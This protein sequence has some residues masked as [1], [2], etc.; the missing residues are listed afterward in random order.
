MR[1]VLF[2]LLTLVAVALPLAAQAPQSVG[3]V[4]R[5]IPAG[6][7]NRG[8]STNE[9]KK[10]DPVEW[11]D[12]L[13]TNDAGRMRVAMDDGSLL[14]IGAHSELRVIK[15]DPQSN[16]TVIEML[17]GKARANVV[18]IKKQ[19]GSFQVRTPTA[20]IG[21]LGTT[22]DV[23]TVQLVGTVTEKD[24]EELP[25]SRRSVADLIQL[26]P[27]A[28]P[29]KSRPDQPTIADYL[30][31][32]TRVTARD[33]AVAVRSIDPEILKT[34]VVLPGYTT[35]VPRGGPPSDP[36]PE[37]GQ[38]QD[39]RGQPVRN[40]EES[41]KRPLLGSCPQGAVTFDSL[42]D[43]LEYEIVGRGT[44]TGSVF[45]VRVKNL[46]DCPLN[47]QIPAGAVLEPKGYVGRVL[48]GIL[49]G[50]GMPPLKDF[51]VMM[52]EGGFDEI[53]PA[54]DAAQDYIPGA[55]YFVPPDAKEVVFQLRGYCL[56]LHKLAPH[57]KT[58]YKFADPGDQK[59]LTAPNLKVMEAANKLAA[60]RQLG[61]Q[62]H[63]LDSI[64]QW[65]LWAAR[66]KMNAKD[67][68]E[69][70]FKLVQKNYEGQKKKF[71]KDAKANTDKMVKD[72][73]PLVEKV[74]AAGR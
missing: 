11:N 73:W 43:A 54:N 42:G 61:S 31:D 46:T 10:A 28:M 50:G 13:R 57:A 20:V 25:A 47:L 18:P 8:A 27:G 22:V 56:E 51:Q 16:Q 17:Y 71:D 41:K 53:P 70:F 33:H 9:A 34:V 67:F 72:L 15:H 45:D 38:T 48:K 65:S 63:T 4:D 26:I 58:K 7:I 62:M 30:I 24:L 2:A 40:I 64:V 44:S 55:F 32:G 29:D 37:S 36:V 74:L 35:F 12:I 66:E 49:L 69:E 68:R 52:A 3:K 59:K 60:L 5:L 14:S 39:Y 6:F 1:R 19:G 21:V 23:E